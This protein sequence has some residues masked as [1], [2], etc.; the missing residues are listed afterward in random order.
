MASSSPSPRISRRGNEERV[1]SSGCLNV[2]LGI[3]PLSVT[4]MKSEPSPMIC[5][6][7]L[8]IVQSPFSQVFVVLVAGLVMLMHSGCMR[9]QQAGHPS[10]ALAVAELLIDAFNRHD[11]AAMA[12]LV[13]PDFELY[14]FDEN[15]VAGLA[16]TGPDQLEAQMTQ[17]FAARP[18]VQSTIS[19]A[20]DGPVYVSFREQIV[21]GQSSI[22]VY[23]IRDDLI[24][25]VWYY[26]AED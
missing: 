5:Q 26:P 20:I 1:F 21:G 11:P 22:A 14:Y 10:G 9:T 8:R 18:S 16:L 17:Y 23:E 6:P 25:R 7:T 4:R 19:G 15:G 3:L 2:E 24:Q 13:S 12:A